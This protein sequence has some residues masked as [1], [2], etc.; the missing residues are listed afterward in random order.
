MTE[1]CNDHATRPRHASTEAAKKARIAPTQMKTVPSGRSDFCM[2]A[3]PAVSG[4]FI[5]GI[6]TPASVGRPERGATLLTPGCETEG[7]ASL[8]VGLGLGAAELCWAAVD[9][10]PPDDCADCCRPL[11]CGAAVLCGASVA[12]APWPSGA[13]SVFRFGKSGFCARTAGATARSRPTRPTEG[14]IVRTGSDNV[15]EESWSW[16]LWWVDVGEDIGQGW[17]GRVVP[18]V[19]SRQAQTMHAK[20]QNPITVKTTKARGGTNGKVSLQCDRFG[21]VEEDGAAGAESK[22]DPLGNQSERGSGGLVFAA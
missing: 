6:P 18:R 1:R 19:R 3:A 5:L 2:K 14:R 10:G 20:W 11:D 12:D 16:S 7:K 15:K 21:G 8:L 17:R 4:T 9:C 13:E 22:C